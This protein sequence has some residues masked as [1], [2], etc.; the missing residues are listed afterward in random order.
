MATIKFECPCCKARHER[1]YVDGV[2]LF[3]CLRC[4]YVGHGHHPDP[5]IDR[6]VHA[7]VLA[8]QAAD[9]RAGMPAHSC[10]SHWPGEAC[11]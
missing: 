10:F 2:S 3:R 8:G 5:E 9:A 11:V 4:G 7:D 1:G 6:G